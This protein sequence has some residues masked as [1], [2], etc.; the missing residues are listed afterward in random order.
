MTHR[1][2]SMTHCGIC[3]RRAKIDPVSGI[4]LACSVHP[5]SSMQASYQSSRAVNE[6]ARFVPNPPKSATCKRHANV[7]ST[8]QT[9]SGARTTLYQGGYNTTGGGGRTRQPQRAA[10]SEQCVVRTQQHVVIAQHQT[11][12][13]CATG[14]G[15]RMEQHEGLW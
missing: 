3:K 4:S 15:V 6:S 8:K 13:W 14:G 1:D 10:Q 9:S 2:Y 7:G 12:E 11:R 5:Q